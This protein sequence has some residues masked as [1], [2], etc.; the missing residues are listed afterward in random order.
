MSWLSGLW[1]G[2]TVVGT[3][4]ILSSVAALG[5]A[6]GAVK[7]RGVGL[8]IAGVLFAGL[9]FGH[10]GVNIQAH[11]LEFVREF[12]LIL[13]VYTIGMQV[14]PGFLASLH[15][16]GLKLN[17][18]ALA[19]VLLGVATTVVIHFVADVP[20][21][22]LVGV[23]SGA[24]TNTPSLAAAQQALVEVL[25]SEPDAASLVKLPGLG[26]AVAYPFG[27]VG[28]ILVLLLLR[29]LFRVRL[30]LR[31]GRPR[32]TPQARPGPECSAPTSR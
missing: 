21:A 14:G 7:V 15:R 11:V 16:V 27:V 8:G 32:G 10:F 29:A 24:V 28:I 30:R 6:L 2:E 25:K 12:G 22:A 13:F 3:V 31:A 23:L 5:L 26:Y 9:V 1:N 19:V 4:L 18:L 17:M 20:T